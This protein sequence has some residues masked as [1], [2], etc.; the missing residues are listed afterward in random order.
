[1]GTACSG[2][3]GC[4]SPRRLNYND[5]LKASRWEAVEKRVALF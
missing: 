5:Y 2:T 1:M 4:L 3:A